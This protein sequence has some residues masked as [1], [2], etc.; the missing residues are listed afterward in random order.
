MRR[1]ARIPAIWRIQ[2]AENEP[3]IR[4]ACFLRANDPIFLRHQG[5]WYVLR[6]EA[7]RESVMPNAE[8]A[9]VRAKIEWAKHHFE[10]VNAAIRSFLR[11][12]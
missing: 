1:N 11:P 6:R 9:G 3:E 4:F 8:L 10:Q 7:Y 5:E 12:D 2:L